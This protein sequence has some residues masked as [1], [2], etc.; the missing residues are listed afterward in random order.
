[1]EPNEEITDSEI[2]ERLERLSGVESVEMNPETDWDY[3]VQLVGEEPLKVHKGMI[4][5]VW[6]M[7]DEILLEQ[8]HKKAQ[9]NR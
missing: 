3:D 1:M 6:Q 4:R 5:D 9:E 7:E 8:L 2:K